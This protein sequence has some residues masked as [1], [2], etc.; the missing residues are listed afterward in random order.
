[1]TQQRLIAI[2]VWIS[3]TAAAPVFATP[4]RFQPDDH[5]ALQSASDV[6]ISPNGSMIA[7]VRQFIDGQHR[8]RSEVWLLGLADG[9]TRRLS[10]DGVDARSPRWSPDGEAV[11][12]LSGPTNVQR[13]NFLAA[14]F[15]ANIVVAHP[16]QGASEIVAQYE[17]SNEPLAYQGTGEQTAWSP[18]GKAIAY[19]SADPGPEPPGTDP[20]VIVRL[21]YKT[22][23][24]MVDNKRWHVYMVTLADKRVQRLTS[25]P[26]HDHTIA[27]SPKGDEIAFIS[28]HEPDPDR[29]HNY[30][31]FAVRVADGTIR[32]ITRTPGCEYS[33][34]WSPDGKFIAYLAG[35]RALTTRESNA[36]DPHAW[37]VPA[38]GGAGRQLAPGLDRRTIGIEWAPDE[39]L[40]YLRV[41]D[42]GNSILYR[43][44]AD[45][46]DLT[47]VVNDVGSLR[48]FSA[49]KGRAV[50]YEFASPR[51]PAEAFVKVQDQAA[52]Q[53]THLNDRLLA[54]REV[55]VPEPFEYS[56]FDGIRV[57]GF[58]TPPLHPLSGQK[59]PLIV[60]IHGGPH[61]QQGPAFVLKSQ[62]YAGNGYAS[63]MVN[64][65]GSTG[66]GQTFADGTLRDQ[67]GSEFKDVIA[68]LDYILAQ[69][70]Y[71]DAERVGVEG[72]SY[73]GQLT[74]WA[75]TQTL[76][77]KAAVASSGIS[78]LVNLAYTHWAPDYMQEEYHGYPWQDDIAASLWAHSA[79]AHIENVKTP[80]MLIHGEEDGDVSVAEA[81]TMYNALRQV[82]VQAVFVRYPRE[83]HGLREPVHVVD[84]MERSLDWYDYFIK[85]KP[86]T[87]LRE[88]RPVFEWYDNMHR[89]SLDA[90]HRSSGTW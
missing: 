6:R 32:Q 47:P 42:H 73:G 24:G 81:E 2:L 85:G 65:R 77:F 4:R 34:T 43:V 11:M 39:P 71:L 84:A 1:M 64:Y 21:G 62:V 30:D 79:V 52:R 15:G 19:L 40:V 86:A 74:N 37:I 5:Y 87:A 16:T 13:S 68:G 8:N 33:P 57:Q 69:T 83:G 17:V 41:E 89:R 72:G 50:A 80:T 88:M 27:W 12:Y 49:A 56:S 7:Y 48:S 54:D 51:A 10:A 29:V 75:V 14:A 44:G 38:S 82:G 9:R 28:N 35:T 60:Q 58:L 78:N 55:S 36:E 67:D 76:R 18:D 70:P 61:S 22:W 90:E 66:Y 3:V 26:Y 59:Y 25:E 53:V 63:L 45:G 31:I 46:R 23:V 20:Y